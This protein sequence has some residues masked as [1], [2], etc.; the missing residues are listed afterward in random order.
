MT[1]STENITL[2]EEMRLGRESAN[3]AFIK[4]TNSSEYFSTNVFCF[5]EGEDGKYYNQ[6]IK[7]I[8]GNNIIAI[9]VGNKNEVLKIWRKIKNDSSYE[10]VSKCFFVDRDMDEYPK[11]ID[12]DLFITPCYSIENLYTT[13]SALE[14]ILQSEFSCEKYDEDY[15]KCLSKFTELQDQ[16]NE[17]MIEFNA[18]VLLRNKKALGNGKVSLSGIKTTNLVTVDI[19]K[20]SKHSKYE[21]SIAGLKSK[22]GASDEEILKCVSELKN[23][24]EYNYLF[25]GKNQLDFFASFIKMMK[26]LHNNK[27]FFGK[28]RNCVSI[29]ITNNRL[30]EL[31]QYAEF[32]V[33]LKCFLNRHKILV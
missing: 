11:D 28:Y 17:I 30:S 29:D 13:K 12:N 21:Q 10:K 25:R 7:T 32:P 19:V 14:N 31:S 24:G 27:E 18:L 20:V 1:V 9:T 16:F 26:R 23:R 15:S 22:L 2:L 3:T 8:L 6:K 33:S 5:Y 4:F